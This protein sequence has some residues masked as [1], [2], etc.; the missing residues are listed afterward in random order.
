MNT[1]YH[2]EIFNSGFIII[3]IQ[4]RKRSFSSNDEMDTYEPNS[5]IAVSVSKPFYEYDQLPFSDVDALHEKNN[6]QN[7]ANEI[8]YSEK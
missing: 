8:Y 6:K 1:K 3:M 4:Q 7:H 5:F 2:S